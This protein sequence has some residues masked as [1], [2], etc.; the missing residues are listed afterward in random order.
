MSKSD[1]DIATEPFDLIKES[2]RYQKPEGDDFLENET[3]DSYVIKRNDYIYGYESDVDNARKKV[4][5]LVQDTNTL[6]YPISYWCTYIS[7]DD[8]HKQIYGHAKSQ[9][10]SYDRLLEDFRLQKVNGEVS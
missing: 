10:E 2:R 6:G 1:S 9:F 5:Q 4:N 7:G 3:K 8:E